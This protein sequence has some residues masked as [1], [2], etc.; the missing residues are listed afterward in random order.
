[1]GI[2][3][4]NIFGLDLFAHYLCCLESVIQMS[5]QPHVDLTVKS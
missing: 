3:K 2:E 4:G 5:T 1:M